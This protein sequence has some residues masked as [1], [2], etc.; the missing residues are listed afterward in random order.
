LNQRQRQRQLRLLAGNGRIELKKEHWKMEK[1]EIYEGLES[2][3]K[4]YISSTKLD[5][6]LGSLRE[7]E[8]QGRFPLGKYV[9][10]CI[11]SH[12]N[13]KSLGSEHKVLWVDICHHCI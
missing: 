6:V 11:D 1:Q 8:E 9:L 2:L 12:S 7:A 3:A 5:E 4:S 13:G 10:A